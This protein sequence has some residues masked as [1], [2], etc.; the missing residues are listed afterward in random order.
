MRATSAVSVTTRCRNA[1]LCMA[2]VSILRELV[3]AWSVSRDGEMRTGISRAFA[4]KSVHSHGFSLVG[5]RV[6]ENKCTLSSS[7]VQVP[8]RVRKDLKKDMDG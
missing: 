2:S 4:R 7:A 8:T 6:M 5:V 1:P 3:D